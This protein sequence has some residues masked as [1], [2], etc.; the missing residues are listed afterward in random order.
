MFVVDSR[1]EKLVA[2]LLAALMIVTRVH[3]FGIGAIAPDASTAIFFL[4]GLML[5]SPWWLL[6]YLA[7][8]VVLDIF[9][10]GFAGVAAACVSGGYVLLAPAYGALWL[11][12]RAMR[13]IERLDLLAAGKILVA[14][15]GG[16]V[17]FFII[18]NIGYFLGS[19]FFALGLV[20]YTAR[21]ARYFPYYAVVTLFYAGVWI[22]AHVLIARF[23]GRG[24]LAIR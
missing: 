20:E 10:I 1:T 24:R 22:V 17:V 18:S 13:S 3:H 21:V 5:A 19:D 8:A 11:S 12:G 15:G 4:V 16:T 2:L 23:A 6:A 14:L 7:L 9:A